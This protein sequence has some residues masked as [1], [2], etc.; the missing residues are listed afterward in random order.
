MAAKMGRKKPANLHKYNSIWEK[1]TITCTTVQGI[2]WV[3]PKC[4][5]SIFGKV[6]V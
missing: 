3:L 2:R 4:V 1:K 6:D 5:Y